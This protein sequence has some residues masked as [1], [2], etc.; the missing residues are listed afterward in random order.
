MKTRYLAALLIAAAVA[1]ACSGSPAPLSQKRATKVADGGAVLGGDPDDPNAPPG[2]GNVLPQGPVESPLVGL[3]TGD[4]QLATI[5]GRGH[6]NALTTALCGGSAVTSL[7]DLQSALKLGFG[8]ITTNGKNGAGGNPAFVLLG[9]STSLVARS[10]SA[11]NPRAVVFT[12]AAGKKSTPGFVAM[13]F[14]RGEQF[15]EIAAHDATTDL[16]SFY[17]V[18]FQQACNANPKGCT[19]GELVTPAIEK[20][21]TGFTVYEDEDLKNTV[22]D[23]RQCHQPGGPSTQATLLMHELKDPWTHWFRNDN[24]GG[25]ALLADYHAAHG[26]SEDYGPVPASLVDKSDGRSLEDLVERN[27]FGAQNVFDSTVIEGEVKRSATNQPSLNAPPGTSATWQQLYDNAAAGNSIPVPYHDVKVTD[28]QKLADMSLA[29]QNFLAGKTQMTDLPDI[30]RVFLLDALPD[31]T[32]RPKAGLD[33]KG[34][35]VQMC[36]QCHNDKLDAS[37]SRARFDVTKLDTMSRAAKDLAIA[38]MQMASTSRLRMPPVIFRSF[39]DES[40]NLAIEELQK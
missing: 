33:G 6:N 36:A 2:I 19:A 1:A 3:P 22:V 9:H 39:T 5:C 15:V 17:L 32:F 16:L 24:A 28:P 13:G 25:V 14:T 21:W 31:L 40:L 10:V 12:T 29:Y 26:A 38:R 30:R 34:V 20:N 8:D 7:T 35:I 23:C 18:V 27:G 37:L 4:A 11:I